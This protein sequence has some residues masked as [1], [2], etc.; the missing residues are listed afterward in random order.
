MSVSLDLFVV[1]KVTIWGE[2]I[3]VFAQVRRG[4]TCLRVRGSRRRVQAVI[5]VRRVNLFPWCLWTRV[6]TQNPSRYK[7]QC[8]TRVFA[9]FKP[10]SSGQR[11]KKLS[12][13]SFLLGE[14]KKK[15]G[16]I[17]IITQSISKHRRTKQ[18]HITPYI[19]SEIATASLT[20]STSLKM[21]SRD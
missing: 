18:P 20:F 7:D 13:V 6:A 10:I 14:R 19:C 12:Y 21:S 11:L 17:S 15:K 5:A 8:F 4:L 2:K 16:N 9:L 3:G 1:K